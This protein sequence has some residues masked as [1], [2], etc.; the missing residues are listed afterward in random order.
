M[1]K[2][3]KFNK[4]NDIEWF[5]PPREMSYG[6]G[7]DFFFCECGNYYRDE[8]F[9]R[10]DMNGNRVPLSMNND[11][12][13]YGLCEKCGCIINFKTHFI[14]GKLKTFTKRF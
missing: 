2:Q 11:L 5:N 3:V 14:L 8:G 7:V 10:C 1:R 13:I 12:N 6:E 9:N 4:E